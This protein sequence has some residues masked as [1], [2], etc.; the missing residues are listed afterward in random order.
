MSNH[1]RF[2]ILKPVD[3]YVK[4]PDGQTSGIEAGNY[5]DQ[6]LLVRSFKGNDNGTIIYSEPLG[7]PVA[8]FDKTKL[9]HPDY[10]LMKSW[11]GGNSC[12]IGIGV[13][14]TKPNFEVLLH[15]NNN[16]F[17]KTRIVV[18]PHQVEL[19]KPPPDYVWPCHACTKYSPRVFDLK[20]KA[21]Q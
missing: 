12:C 5:Q 1:Y 18:A 10:V 8:D 6:T 16:F 7:S 13:F 9:L 4:K 19:H 17:D 14:K 15:H 11:T 21:W 3:F 2:D 20:K